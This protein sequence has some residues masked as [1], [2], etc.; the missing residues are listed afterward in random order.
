MDSLPHELLNRI[1]LHLKAEWRR[2]PDSRHVYWRIPR[3]PLA[4]YAAVSR[5][6]QSIVEPFTFRSLVLNQMRLDV[7][8]AY[9][10]LTPA[11]LAH[12][13]DV[14]FDIEFPGHD[15]HVSTNP[16]DYDDQ[17]VFN[18]TIRQMLAL[19]SRVPHRDTPLITLKLS[20]GPSREHCI[21][22]VG[23]REDEE[24]KVFSGKLRK[25]YLELP[26][27]WDANIQDV[28]EIFLF[29][30]QLESVAMVF[31]PASI[32][33]MASKM[34]RLKQVEW[35]LCDGEKINTEL[36][37]RQRTGEWLEMRDPEAE[38]DEFDG[39]FDWDDAPYSEIPGEEYEKRF[40]S[41]HNPIHFERFALAT[42]RAAS[43]MPKIRELYVTHHSNAEMG[44]G[45]VTWGLKKSCCLEFT[46]QP[47][48]EP[49]E[50]VLDAWRKAVDLHGME[51]NVHLACWGDAYYFY[52]L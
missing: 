47:S 25:T 1:I 14:T 41:I 6:W 9:N 11:R 15:L 21:P 34:T 43:Q 18:K 51:W 20:I 3:T 28:S 7:A 45:F 42:A 39:N 48:R 36:R 24:D 37:I 29:R 10:Y 40:D 19:L 33:R 17:I 49:S 22:W 13:R 30:V 2:D 46:R 16:E 12:L 23:Y 38:E 26:A 35:W 52:D 5:K 8:E 4:T 44:V 50:E 31:A 27:D 32:N